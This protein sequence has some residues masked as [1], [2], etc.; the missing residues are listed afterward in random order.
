MVR[1]VRIIIT[2]I[3][4]KNNKPLIKVLCYGTQCEITHEKDLDFD[5]LNKIIS[6]EKAIGKTV[7][8]QTPSNKEK[9]DKIKTHIKESVILIN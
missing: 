1:N 9:A 8:I 7:M 2:D 4:E 6:K 5:E 3:S